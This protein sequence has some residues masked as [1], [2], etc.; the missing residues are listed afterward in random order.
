[1]EIEYKKNIIWIA[2]YPKSGNTWFRVFLSNLFSEYDQPVNINSLHPTPLASSRLL[3]EEYVGIQSSELTNHEIDLL[4]PD[5]YKLLSQNYDSDLFMKVH[6]AWQL[7]CNDKPLFPNE[8]TKGVIYI[9]RNPY[10][11]AKSYA[12]HNGVYLSEAI[13]LLNDNNNSVSRSTKKSSYQLEQTI[14]SW[15]KHAE[16]WI[17]HSKLPVHVLRY[18]D[19]LL[20]PKLHFK[21]ALDFLGIFYNSRQISS[22]IENSDFKILAEQEKEFGFIEKPQKSRQFFKNGRA[23]DL[24]QLA[25]NQHYQILKKKHAKMMKRFKYFN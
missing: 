19:L 17:D 20:N 18:E 14:F 21:N 11:V 22:A 25:G 7:N 5:V 10:D 8:I 1:M 24:E 3:F 15:S 6:D 4:R 9:I 12:N 2:S 13:S 16:S 23:S